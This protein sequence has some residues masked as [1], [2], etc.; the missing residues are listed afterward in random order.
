M[1]TYELDAR[2]RILQAA[3]RLFRPAVSFVTQRC[4]GRS[5]KSYGQ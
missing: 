4:R 5:V 2:V 1:S 3:K